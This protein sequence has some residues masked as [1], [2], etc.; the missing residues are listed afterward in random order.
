MKYLPILII[1]MTCSTAVLAE[2]KNTDSYTNNGGRGYE[3]VPLAPELRE[4][5]QKGKKHGTSIGE[6]SKRFLCKSTGWNFFCDR[7]R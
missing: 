4:T 2:N 7:S 5:Y 6:W 3:S 1:F